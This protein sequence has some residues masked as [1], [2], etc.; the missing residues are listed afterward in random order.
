MRKTLAV[1]GMAAMVGACGPGQGGADLPTAPDFD[2]PSVAGPTVAL[3]DFR[4][5]PV[6]LYFHMAVG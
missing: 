3:D 2:L 5:R 6:L 4:G 1:L